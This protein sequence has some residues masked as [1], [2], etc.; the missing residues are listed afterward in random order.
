MVYHLLKGK[1]LRITL[2]AIHTE[3]NTHIL[4]SA[5]HVFDPAH[6]VFDISKNRKCI[7]RNKSNNKIGSIY[8]S[9]RKEAYNNSF[10]YNS[11]HHD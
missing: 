8:L 1:C 4:Y 6:L 5:S 3:M 10:D 7:Y 9:S 2:T 11:N